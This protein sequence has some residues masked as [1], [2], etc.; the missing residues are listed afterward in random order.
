MLILKKILVW[1]KHH[2]YIPLAAVLGLVCLI[3]FPKSAKSRYFQML[4]NTRYNYKK[5]IDI[6]NK[7]NKLE[8][9]KTMDAIKRH[10]ESLAK[11]EEDF[12]VKMDELP[13]KEKKRVEAIVKEFNND[14]DKLAEEIANILG[15]DNV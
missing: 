12:N 7:N 4:L 1:F 13:K 11:V 9:E 8:K 2:W 6:I 15:A 14:P 5:Q 3:F 10:Q